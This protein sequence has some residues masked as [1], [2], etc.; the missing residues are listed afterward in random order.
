MRTGSLKKNDAQERII[1]RRMHP[2]PICQ[3]HDH[4]GRLVC[5]LYKLDDVSQTPTYISA[6]QENPVALR[7]V[8][9]IRTHCIALQSLILMRH[10][11][12]EKHS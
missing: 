10:E 9:L 3:H 7:Y 12:I 8:V 1:L 5:K 4:R 11:M 2:F 6:D